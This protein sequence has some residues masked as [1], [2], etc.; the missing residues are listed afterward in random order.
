M[1]PRNILEQIFSHFHLISP[2]YFYIFPQ[3]TYIWRL[4][5]NWI[6]LHKRC[7]LKNHST[8]GPYVSDVSE[9]APVVGGE[10]LM[11]TRPLIGQE[12][13]LPDSDWTRATWLYLLSNQSRRL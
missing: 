9:I 12:V 7:I 3:V 2:S 5:S 13:Q 6:E 1:S 11:Q 4:V 8:N 10:R